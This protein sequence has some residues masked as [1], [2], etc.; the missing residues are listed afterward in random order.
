MASETSAVETGISK[1][2]AEKL[3]L[4]TDSTFYILS[5]C[6]KGYLYEFNINTES[7]IQSASRPPLTRC[8]IAKYNNLIYVV[9]GQREEKPSD[10]ALIYDINKKS[11]TEHNIPIGNSFLTVCTVGDQMYLFGGIDSSET[12]QNT[13]FRYDFE[14]DRLM[15][16]ADMEKYRGQCAVAY[17]NSSIYVMGGFS[18][19]FNN[20]VER[21]DP[22]EGK[23]SRAGEINGGG[24]CSS[25]LVKDT[26]HVINTYTGK[27][28]SFDPRSLR[29]APEKYLGFEGKQWLA[30]MDNKLY[31][32]HF[33]GISVYDEADDK[34][35]NVLNYTFYKC[36]AFIC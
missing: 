3:T 8:A 2:F 22:R 14:T 29:G 9:A 26:V 18:C 25:A 27:Y 31:L 4:D 20:A 19:W 10:A 17:Y 34:W 33:G 30:S 23:W 12:P 16:L 35:A 6:T 5:R 32:L 1:D 36:P 11:W 13:C 21:Y 28:C 15:K 24:A 7:F